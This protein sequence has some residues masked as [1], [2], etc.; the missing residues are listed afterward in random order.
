MGLP[1]AAWGFLLY[2]IAGGVAFAGAW[3]RRTPDWWPLALFGLAAFGATF[4]AY[5]IWLQLAVIHA[6]CIW[7]TISD[8]LWMVLLVVALW[9]ARA[10]S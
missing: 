2:L 4:S 5:L 10:A 3:R 9:V 6:V 1:T 7:C 8:V